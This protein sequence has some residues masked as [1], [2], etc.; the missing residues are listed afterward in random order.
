[1][2]NGEWFCL[3]ALPLRQVLQFKL[4][5]DLFRKCHKALTPWNG[6]ENFS[7]KSGFPIVPPG[8]RHRKKHLSDLPQTVLSICTHQDAYMQHLLLHA[9]HSIPSLRVLRNGGH[10]GFSGNLRNCIIGACFGVCAFLFFLTRP[11]VYRRSKVTRALISS[12]VKTCPRHP[13]SLLFLQCCQR[14]EKYCHLESYF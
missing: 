7:K 9:R 1:M 13:K 6:N 11:C 3:S 12:G 2:S 5:M 8:E 4:T 10:Y 14:V